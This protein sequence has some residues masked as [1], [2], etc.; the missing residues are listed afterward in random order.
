MRMDEFLVPWVKYYF[1]SIKLDFVSKSL[2]YW[3]Q[4]V[5]YCMKSNERQRR[6]PKFHLGN[7]SCK[8]SYFSLTLPRSLITTTYVI[9]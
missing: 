5:L 7:L 3:Q 1:P 8:P 6:L 9:E 4:L 2:H